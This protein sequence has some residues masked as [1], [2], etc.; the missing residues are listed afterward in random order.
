MLTSFAQA[1]KIKLEDNFFHEKGFNVRDLL[2][3]MK[4][5]GL[6][7]DE[8]FKEITAEEYKKHAEKLGAK[9]AQLMSK[10]A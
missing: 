2:T 1:E 10:I 5:K 7:E 4:E 6:D 9:T 8:R 3:W